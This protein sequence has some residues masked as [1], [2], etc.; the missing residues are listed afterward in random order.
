MMRIA[1]FG[2]IMLRLSPPGREK[3][4]QSPFFVALFGGG[5][6]NVAA[7]LARFNHD[8]RFISVVP[9]NA[10]GDA[11]VAELRR[12][13][14][15]TEFIIRKGR[16]LGIYFAET[17]A[18]QRPSKVVYDREHSAIAEA[19]PGDI[20]WDRAFEGVDWFHTSGITPAISASA[21]E[22]SL[23][24]LQAAKS[25]GIKVSVDLN[26]RGKLWKY[27][28]PAPDVMR[29]VLAL[30]D[31]A[32]GNEE[33]CQRSLGLASV[34]DIRAGR[35]DPGAYDALTLEV[36]G[37]FPN[38]ER[39]ALTLR[40]S[41]SASWNRWSAVLRDSGGFIR[42]PLYEIHDIVDRIGSGDAFAA[43]LIH[44]LGKFGTVAEALSFAVAASCLKHSI[45]GDFNL[46]SEEDVLAL[47]RGEGSGRVQR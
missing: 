4:L 3:L 5:E 23:E 18:D 44:G 29:R 30:A 39:I 33:D 27:G 2:E 45:P 38:L 37:Q 17:G 47:M 42:G 11:A 26:Y 7:S 21:A 15:R 46:V 32:I 28:T 19:G 40:E 16:R 1:T 22:L 14:V 6:A 36:M 41:L 10:V 34:A 13:Q 35:L 12:R 43:G 20:D 31:V 8:T 24:G 25:K 9:D